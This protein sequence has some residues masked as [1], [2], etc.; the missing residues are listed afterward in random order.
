MRLNVWILAALAACIVFPQAV[1]ATAPSAVKTS[2]DAQ[3]G[4]LNV[5]VEHHVTGLSKHYIQEVVVT[6]NGEEVARRTFD[7]QT[8]H[9]EQ[10]MPPFKLHFAPR[11]DVKVRATDNR[12]SSSSTTV[13]LETTSK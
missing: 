7:A 5:T 11:D 1:L 12:G 6:K 3:R 13:D 9:R 2:Y 4:E 10:T 8:S